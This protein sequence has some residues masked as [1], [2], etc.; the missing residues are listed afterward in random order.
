M[1]RVSLKGLVTGIL[2]ENKEK[3]NGMQAPSLF[4]YTI[5]GSLLMLQICYPCTHFLEEVG[6]CI[7][8]EK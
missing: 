2:R 4:R 8:I 5:T 1:T 6:I 3:H 7:I